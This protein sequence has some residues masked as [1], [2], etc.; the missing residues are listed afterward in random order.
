MSRRLETAR[1]L[2]PRSL[3]GWLLLVLVLGVHISLWWIELVPGPRGL[4]GDEVTYWQRALQGAENDVFA[5]MWPPLYPHF[6]RLVGSQDLVRGL[7]WLLLLGAAVLL[8]DVGKAL[9]LETKVCRGAALFVV[10]Y[11]PLIAYSLYFWPEVLH[12]FLLVLVLWCLLA[13]A[14]SIPWALVAGGGLGAA[15]STKSLLLPFVPILLWPMVVWPDG[16]W[17]IISGPRQHIGEPLSGLRRLRSVGAPAAMLIALTSTYL[18]SVVASHHLTGQW[19]GGGSG[20]FNLWV[21]LEDHSR[22]SLEDSVVW[23]ELQRWRDSGETWQQRQDVLWAKIRS[24]VRQRGLPAVLCGQLVKQ[25]FRFFDHQTYLSAQ[26]PGGALAFGA[27]GYRRV[28]ASLAS[29]IR[30]ISSA[31]YA[32]LLFLALAG[33]VLRPPWEWEAAS[34]R[35]GWWVL[36]LLVAYHLILFL[37]L[38]VKSRYRLQLLPALALYASLGW[39]TLRYGPTAGWLR[40]VLIITGTVALWL[41]AFGVDSLFRM[42]LAGLGP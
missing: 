6:L 34:R 13:R 17:T 10:A 7:Q 29:T 36:T 41:W 14:G 33:F 37:G 30:G 28:P 11:P 15:L 39:H 12:L 19:L 21:G 26:L 27:R 2:C 16:L 1:R 35:I 38:H 24:R 3:P 9:G 4:N 32:G 8:A 31:M 20:L 18:P 25:P 22:R 40:R 42:S 5:P 23:E